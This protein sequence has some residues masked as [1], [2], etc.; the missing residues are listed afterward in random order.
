MNSYHWLFLAQPAPLPEHLIGHDP[1]FYLHHLLDRWAGRPDRSSRRRSPNT[2]G[3][4]ANR[5]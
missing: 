1:D 2:P 4:S 3:T 5:R